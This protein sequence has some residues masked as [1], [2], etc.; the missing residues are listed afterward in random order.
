MISILLTILAGIIK[1]ILA[2]LLLFLLLLLLVLFVP[3]RYKGSFQKQERNMEAAGTISWLLHFVSLQVRWREKNLVWEVKVFGIS[4]KKLLNRFRNPE[5]TAHAE[6][7]EDQNTSLESNSSDQEIM[8]GDVQPEED[9]SREQEE[10]GEGVQA[11]SEDPSQSMD[12]AG[13]TA[14]DSSRDNE[15]GIDIEEEAAGSD[16]SD[17]GGSGIRQSTVQRLIE[18]ISRF[19]QLP[20]KVLAGIRSRWEKLSSAGSRV[21]AVTEQGKRLQRF[22]QS[23]LFKEV[24]ALTKKELLAVIRHILPRS[25]KGNL[26]FGTDDPGTTGQILAGIAAVYPILPGN[27]VVNPD[28]EKTVLNCNL[29]VKGR[30]RLSVLAYHGCR[31]LLNRQV[32]RLISRIRHKEAN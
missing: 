16:E 17:D 5:K 26:E 30:I 21:K 31:L 3:V 9:E 1:I 12:P 19:L 13:E 6:P 8:N 27:L 32:R 23:N 10:T 18:R 15:S 24:F 28:F 29:S 25:V 20:E 2:L 11:A 22:L 14:A 7:E 4:L